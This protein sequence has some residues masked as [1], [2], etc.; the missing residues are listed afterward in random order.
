M[1]VAGGWF[2]APPP[3]PLSLKEHCAVISTNLKHLTYLSKMGLATSQNQYE[4]E[5]HQHRCTCVHTCARAHTHT[6]THTLEE[7]SALN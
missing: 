6:H 3:P 4:K 5:F 2:C 7:Q 1:G